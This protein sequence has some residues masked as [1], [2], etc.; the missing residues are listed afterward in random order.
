MTL[1]LPLYAQDKKL[2]GKWGGGVA[3][4]VWTVWTT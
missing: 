1:E 2:N 4:L 3:E